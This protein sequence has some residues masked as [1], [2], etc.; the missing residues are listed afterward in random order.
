MGLLSTASLFGQYNSVHHFSWQDACFNNPRLPYCMGHDSA[1]TQPKGKSNSLG[2][3]FLDPPIDNVTPAQIAA[4]AIDWRFA[5]PSSDALVGFHAHKL[6]ALPLARTVIGRLAANQGIIPADV[7]RL[8]ERLSGVDQVAI[9]VRENQ[10]VIMITGRGADSTLPSVE[11]GWKAVPVVGNAL[12]V[13]Q[14]DAVDQAVQRMGS[15]APPSQLMR[16]ATKRHVGSE[17]WAVASAGQVGQQAASMKV[18]RLAL[19][20]WIRDLITC[21]L[22][23][24]FD[25]PPDPK[26]LGTWPPALK[27]RI[28]GNVLHVTT[29]MEADDL[30]QKFAQVVAASPIGE[31]LTA[32]VQATPYLPM[33]DSTVPKRPKAVIYGLDGGPTALNQ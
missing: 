2:G 3:S 23:L 18:K 27:G 7:E 26:L 31:Q 30:Q 1:V 21:D 12:L 14:A 4:G 28:A 16:M 9:S 15:D 13:G 24:E 19:T 29:I 33:R 32:L 5:D 8:F 22:D 11:E 6:A 20:V 10:M 25:G 17:F